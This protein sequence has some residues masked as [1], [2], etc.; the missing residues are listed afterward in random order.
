MAS[1]PPA[2]AEAYL[3]LQAG[4]AAGALEA[5]RRALAADPSNARA[6]LVEGIALRL[7]NRLGEAA[8]A[9]ARAQELDPRDSAAAYEAG[10]VRQLQGDPEGA[11]E[12]FERSAQL[13]PEFFAAHFSAGLLRADRRE[14]TL[15]AACFRRVLEL[16]PG[17]PEAL[18]HLALV[19][20]REGR[21]AEAEATF[22]QALASHPGH[23]GIVR[24]FGQYSASRGNFRRAASLFAEAARLQPADT[25]LPMFLAQC[26]LLTGRWAEGWAAYAGREPRR[27][28]E[29]SAAARGRPYHVPAADSLQGRT[30]TIL[31]EQGLGDALFFLRWVPALRAAGTRVRFAGDARLHGLLERTRLFDAFDGPQAAESAE[32]VVLGGDLPSLFP[33]SDPLAMPSLAIAPLPERM[34]KWKTALEAAGPRPWLGVQ[35]RAGTP[36]E[37]QAHALSKNAPLEALFTALA[38]VPGTLVAIQRELRPG[39][40]EKAR[41]AAGRAV[42]DMSIVNNELEDVLALV[43]LLDRHVA[44]SSTTLHL[45]AAAG[46]TADVLLPFPPEWRWRREGDSPWFPGFRVHRQGVEGDWSAALAG[47]ARGDQDSG[48]Q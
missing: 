45:A 32:I 39:E 25:T 22:V 21:H 10:V 29:R 46:A 36:R 12:R 4:D 19:L 8:S 1:V 27:T 16:R 31:G 40:I 24:A 18:L 14:W 35:W 44:V 42:H 37:A 11:L 15:A 5:A 7:V 34:A 47:A 9:L 3:R 43:A 17:Q 41:R 20:A 2:V 13:R 48:L 38:A 6:C 33:G 30:V 28:F 23:E 26:E